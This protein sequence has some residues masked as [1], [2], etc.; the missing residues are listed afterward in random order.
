MELKVAT[1][2]AAVVKFGEVILEL[3]AKDKLN[4]RVKVQGGTWVDELD[5]EVPSGQIAVIR[6]SMNITEKAE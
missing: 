4:I 1:I 2:D 5:Y 3:G 6:Q